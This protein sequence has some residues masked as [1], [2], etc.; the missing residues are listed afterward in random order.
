M[1]KLLQMNNYYI[2]G[3]PRTVYKLFYSIFVLFKN[4]IPYQSKNQNYVVRMNKTHN[5]Y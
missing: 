3:S 5:T 2:L 1:N 4:P